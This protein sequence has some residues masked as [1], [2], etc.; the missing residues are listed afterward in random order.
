M[1]SVEHVRWSWSYFSS[2]DGSRNG[3]PTVVSSSDE[4]IPSGVLMGV[5]ATGAGFV[6]RPAWAP[7]NRPRVCRPSRW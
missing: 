1:V 5:T 2:E 6:C 7:T 3:E 4:L